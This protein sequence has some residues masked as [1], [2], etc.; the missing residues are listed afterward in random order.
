M[1]AK[2]Y[3]VSLG[4]AK[5]GKGRM[6]KEAHAAI[7]KAIGEGMSFS[8]YQTKVTMTR[9][10]ENGAVV[11]STGP[12]DEVINPFGDAFMRYPM[13]QRFSYVDDNGKQHTTSGRPAC[14]NCGYSL[15]GHTCNS[16][17]VLTQHGQRTVR[18]IGE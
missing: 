6:S 9:Q 12:A 8:D 2:D 15:V 11:T 3:A 17:V 4:L 13:D 5:P 7:Q 16:P 14:M 1:K 18:P 10:A